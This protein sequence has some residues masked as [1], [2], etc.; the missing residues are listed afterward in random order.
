SPED[1]ERPMSNALYHGDNLSV[2]RARVPVGSVGLIYLD[3]PF[4][5]QRDYPVRVPA[6][7]GV[8]AAE[9][10]AFSDTWEWNEGAYQ[11]VMAGGSGAASRLLLRSIVEA[12]G[13]DALSA[14][15]VMMAPRLEELHRALALDG[16]LYLHCD[17]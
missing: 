9:A 4:A 12:R 17:P 11:A 15:L 5:S 10:L 2:L 6:T 1:T 3:P 16:S 14:Y 8:D 7:D 13:R